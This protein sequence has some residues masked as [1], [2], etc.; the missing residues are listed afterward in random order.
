MPSSPARPSRSVSGFVARVA[1][2]GDGVGDAFGDMAARLEFGGLT[3]VQLRSKIIPLDL[4]KAVRGGGTFEFITV[5]FTE[6]WHL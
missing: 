1:E 6:K 4:K 5:N 3:K 2:F